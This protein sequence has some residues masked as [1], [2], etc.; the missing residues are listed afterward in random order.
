MKAQRFKF[1]DIIENGW[2]GEGNP[3]KI[4]IFIRHKKRTIEMT[5]GKGKFWEVYHDSDNKNKKIGTIFENVDL[6]EE[7]K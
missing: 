6:L 4:G 3:T 2:A 5:N 7:S 1:G